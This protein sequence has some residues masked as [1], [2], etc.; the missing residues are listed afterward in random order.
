MVGYVIGIEDAKEVVW[1]FIGFAYK[2]VFLCVGYVFGKGGGNHCGSVGC[3][4]HNF[5][6]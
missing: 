1:N 3:G 4:D 5:C 2:C 6:S